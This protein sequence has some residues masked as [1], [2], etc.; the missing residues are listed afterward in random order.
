MAA[1]V[2]EVVA[3]ADRA[4]RQHLLP[5]RHDPRFHVVSGRC[6]ARLGSGG[7]AGDGLGSGERRAVHFSVGRARQGFQENES[8]RDHRVGK[9]RLEELAQCHG[10]GPGIAVGHH[11]RHEPHLAG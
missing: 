2:E 1:Q 10:S 5:D 9:E 11:P 3:Y 7:C 6:V 8:G 4:H